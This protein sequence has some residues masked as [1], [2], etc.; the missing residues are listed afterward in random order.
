MRDGDKILTAQGLPSART[1]KMQTEKSAV[2]CRRCGG[3]GLSFSVDPLP[4]EENRANNTV[5]RLVNVQ[6]DK[7]RILYIE[8]EPRWEYKFI[9]RAEETDRIVQMF[10]MVRT[11]EN[12]IYRQGISRSQR[13]CR[14]IPHQG[15]GPVPLS[16]A[17]HRFGG[18]ELLHAGAAGV[19]QAISSTGAAAG[20]CCWEAVSP[21]RM[22]AGA[23]PPW[24]ICF[25]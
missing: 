20:C 12:K 13:T 25:R 5:T 16:G 4:G 15:G 17:H 23:S 7:Q 21:W 18:S 2:Q 19:D 6:S 14:R 1:A 3:Q 11:T 10:S 24:P 8:G 22:A 9:R